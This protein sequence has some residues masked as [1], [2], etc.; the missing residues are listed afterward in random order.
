MYISILLHIINQFH[1]KSVFFSKS[2]DGRN[3]AINTFMEQLFKCAD[4]TFSR[5]YN[6]DYKC[7]IDFFYNSSI[8]ERLIK[9]L[10]F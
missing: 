3:L 7:D 2:R 10:V 8:N 5:K 6:H 9:R 1:M 4:I